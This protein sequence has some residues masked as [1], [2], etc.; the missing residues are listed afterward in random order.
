MVLGSLL[1]WLVFAYIIITT[2]NNNAVNAFYSLALKVSELFV[3][4][5]G[6]ACGFFLK[7]AVTSADVAIF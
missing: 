2:I 6:K 3:S 4:D 7:Q 1:V 5:V